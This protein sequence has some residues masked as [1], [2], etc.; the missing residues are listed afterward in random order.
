MSDPRFACPDIDG[1]MDA[2]EIARRTERDGE[3]YLDADGPREGFITR[4]HWANG[5][6]RLLTPE[7]YARL[8]TPIGA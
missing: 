2:A 7:A 1:P 6:A 4:T 3:R 5:N 8:N